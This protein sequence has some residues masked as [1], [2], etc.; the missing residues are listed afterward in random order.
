MGSRQVVN[1]KDCSLEGNEA[2]NENAKGGAVTQGKSGSKSLSSHLANSLPLPEIPSL[3][4]LLNTCLRLMGPRRSNSNNPGK[5]HTALEI[6]LV[7]PT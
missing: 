2:C 1:D 3:F 4:A 5:I 6:H 7:M